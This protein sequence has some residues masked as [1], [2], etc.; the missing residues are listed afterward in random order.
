MLTGQ[1]LRQHRVTGT[2]RAAVCCGRGSVDGVL[3]MR[4]ETTAVV[5]A[6]QRRRRTGF[7]AAACAAA[8]ATGGAACR[9]TAATRTAA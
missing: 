2:S 7:V 6:D 9:L 5:S 8:A 4:A 1:Q 3:V